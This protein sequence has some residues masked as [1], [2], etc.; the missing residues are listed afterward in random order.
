MRVSPAP[1]TDEADC[2]SSSVTSRVD[3][4]ISDGVKVEE[5]T[6]EQV[7]E[8]MDDSTSSTVSR[9]EVPHCVEHQPYIPLQTAQMAIE[10]VT[11]N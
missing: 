8:S 7:V 10:R 4:F 9:L 6:G 11:F 2:A 3:V 5:T 1:P